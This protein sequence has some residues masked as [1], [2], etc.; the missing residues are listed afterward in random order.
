[1]SLTATPPLSRESR[2]LG[3]QPHDYSA[4]YRPYLPSILASQMHRTC[5]IIPSNKP[6]GQNPLLPTCKV[7]CIHCLQVP[8]MIRHLDHNQYLLSTL[9]YPTYPYN[10]N[11]FSRNHCNSPSYHQAN[12]YAT[13]MWPLLCERRVQMPRQETRKIRAQPL[14]PSLQSL[15]IKTY[16]TQSTPQGPNTGGR[17]EQ[18]LAL[19]SPLESPLPIFTTRPPSNLDAQSQLEG[20]YLAR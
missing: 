6:P 16:P 1:V 4:V 2:Q 15:T 9:S 5:L 8:D 18:H 7:Q 12:L 14:A 11:H 19:P 10:V 13:P 3:I 17:K 20:R